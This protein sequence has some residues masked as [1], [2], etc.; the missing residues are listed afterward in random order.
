MLSNEQKLFKAIGKKDPKKVKYLIKQSVDVNFTD[1]YQSTPLHLATYVGNEKIVKHLLKAGAQLNSV[2]ALRNTPLHVAVLRKNNNLVKL[3]LENGADVNIPNGSS[4][5]ALHLAVK[6]TTKILGLFENPINKSYK[7]AKTL[8]EFG[9]SVDVVD[10]AS[11]TPLL[12]AAEKGNYKLID[13]LVQH[14]AEFFGNFSDNQDLIDSVL[15]RPA[16]VSWL[17]DI[18]MNYY[19]YSNQVT[20]LYDLILYRSLIYLEHDR[21][22][23][24]KELANYLTQYRIPEIDKL[25]EVLESITK[26]V[27]DY[28]ILKAIVGNLI[29]L[30]K[31][32]NLIGSTDILYN[33]KPQLKPALKEARGNL[34]PL[35]E[36]TAER[37][38]YFLQNWQDKLAFTKSPKHYPD[39]IEELDLPYNKDEEDTFPLMDL[40]LE[41]REKIGEYV[42]YNLKNN[43]YLE[44][45]HGLVA[46]KIIEDIE[47][48]KNALEEWDSIL[49]GEDNQD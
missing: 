20:N 33:L 24:A 22:K 16:G 2:D 31:E 27:D 41:M 19:K 35:E 4:D 8:L 37:K 23:K 18:G 5:T 42:Y 44:N 6:G 9:A 40:P 10:G 46:G 17:K 30:T 28:K 39:G 29:K 15:E 45:G 3:L 7:I 25:P 47:F 26:N 1:E 48:F 38:V 12:Y 11:K 21:S 49:T 14:G 13:L 36:E 32:L 43:H 34:K